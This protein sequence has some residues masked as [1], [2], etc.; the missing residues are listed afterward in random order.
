MVL[1]LIGNVFGNLDQEAFVQG[2]ENESKLQALQRANQN[3]INRDFF[4]D[5][6]GGPPAIEA[7]AALSQGM[8]GLN[9]DGFGGTYIDIPPPMVDQEGGVAQ[10]ID[11]A[12]KVDDG[13]TTTE[14]PVVTDPNQLK[15]T[16]PVIIDEPDRVFRNIS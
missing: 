4:R 5:Q 1:G 11:E 3:R 10:G 12:D 16:D 8:A 9:I 6:Q 13:T 2:A 7:P 14:K 15:P